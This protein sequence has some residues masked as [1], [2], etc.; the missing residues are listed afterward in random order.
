[1][2]KNR[3]LLIAGFLFAVASS[4]DK[5]DAV[6]GGKHIDLDYVA[7]PPQNN[8]TLVAADTAADWAT[9][10]FTSP[11]LGNVCPFVDSGMK[12]TATGDFTGAT[13]TLWWSA[14]DSTNFALA[15]SGDT[16]TGDSEKVDLSGVYGDSAGS[17]WVT[18]DLTFAYPGAG[19]DLTAVYQVMQADSI[20]SRLILSPDAYKFSE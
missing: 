20:F 8:F 10:R 17:L 15:Q 16:W 14:T 5:V 7:L 3:L 13:A 4:C 6:C 12:V 9:V 11:S 2:M 1:M 19:T 18:V